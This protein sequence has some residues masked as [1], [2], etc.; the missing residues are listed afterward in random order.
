MRRKD[1]AMQSLD[2]EQL[3]RDGEYGVLSS[4]GSDDQPY[5]VPLNYVFMNSCLYF[6][7]AHLGQKLDNIANNQKVS[8]CVVGRTEVLPS[9]FSTGFESV[10]V[11]GTATII[12]GDERYKAL[13]GLVEKYSPDYLE[14]GRAYINRFDKETSVVKVSVD[15]ISGKAKLTAKMQSKNRA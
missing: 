1:K 10:I 6:H 15:K 7:C 14:E 4:V 2:A 11:F 12:E 13:M 3:L 5:G 8:F 9:E